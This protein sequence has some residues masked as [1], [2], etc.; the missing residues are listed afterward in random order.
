MDLNF[1]DS[2]WKYVCIQK[3]FQLNMS[4][5]EIQ[6]M[7]WMVNIKFVEKECN[8][9]RK[10]LISLT[11]VQSSPTVSRCHC[12]AQTNKFNIIE[13]AE[14]NVALSLP[15]SCTWTH[16]KDYSRWPMMLLRLH[17]RKYFFMCSPPVVVA[18]KG[19]CRYPVA[20]LTQRSFT[21]FSLI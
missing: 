2:T 4:M 12:R 14:A 11:F 1:S 19:N 16:H 15:E 21:L 7:V 6:Y 17:E 5:S 13:L 3:P 10:L 9:R 20:L 18:P 8:S